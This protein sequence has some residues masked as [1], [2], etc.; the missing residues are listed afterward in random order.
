MGTRVV[1]CAE[2]GWSAARRRGPLG[3]ARIRREQCG[4]EA[5]GTGRVETPG[6][7]PGLSVSRSCALGLRVKGGGIVGLSGGEGRERNRISR[8]GFY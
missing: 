3:Q 7:T 8:V 6:G 2:N 1:S 5:R 4:Y